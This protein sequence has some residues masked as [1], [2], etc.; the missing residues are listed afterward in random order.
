MRKH[1]K[2]EK[3]IKKV[4]DKPKGVCYSIQARPSESEGMS[5]RTLKTI[6]RRN[7]QLIKERLAKIPKSETTTDVK[8]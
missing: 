6:Q 7:S 4:L 5:R 2:K 1:E 8:D 3:K